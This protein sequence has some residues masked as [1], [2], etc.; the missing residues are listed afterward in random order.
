[1]L[2]GHRYFV[3]TIKFCE[4]DRRLLLLAGWFLGFVG[5]I[6]FQVVQGVEEVGA[7]VFFGI[8]DMLFRGCQLV[9]GLILILLQYCRLC[10]RCWG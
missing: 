2:I 4:V 1:V 7:W 5:R 10:I 3:I 8:G 6:I 9:S